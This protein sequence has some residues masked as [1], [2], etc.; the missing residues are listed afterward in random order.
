MEFV[1]IDLQNSLACGKNPHQVE[2]IEELPENL[3]GETFGMAWAITP[4]SNYQADIRQL[5][6][7]P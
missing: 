1:L 2:S 6:Y 7:S 5:P 4:S 3:T